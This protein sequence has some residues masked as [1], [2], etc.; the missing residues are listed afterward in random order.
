VLARLRCYSS[1]V[2]KLFAAAALVFLI[3]CGGADELPG[4]RVAG[5]GMAPAL[6]EGAY[7]EYQEPDTVEVGD[8]VA[9]EMAVDGVQRGFIKRV[10]AV[11]GQ[12]VEVADGVVLVDGVPLDESG[13][14]ATAP[15]YTVPATEVAAD[16]VYVLGDNRDDSIDS[17]DFG[18]VP[19]SSIH[20]VVVD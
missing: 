19:V 9:F 20:G 8:I 2:L 6:P 11:A 15:Q 12:T 14:V 10:V 4:G 5:N 16:H 3:A 7:F 13:Y 17:H 18:P 1:A